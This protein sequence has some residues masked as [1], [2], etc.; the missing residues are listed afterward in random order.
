MAHRCGMQKENCPELFNDFCFI[1]FSCKD[2]RI[3]TC[4][5][6]IEWIR[7]NRTCTSLHGLWLPKKLR[8]RSDCSKFGRHAAAARG[9]QGSAVSLTRS[10]TSG[11]KPC[12]SHLPLTQTDRREEPTGGQTAALLPIRM[13]GHLHHP[14]EAQRTDSAGGGSSPLSPLLPMLSSA[15]PPPPPVL[16]SPSGKQRFPLILV[17]DLCRVFIFACAKMYGYH[18]FSLLCILEFVFKNGLHFAVSCLTG[19]L[20]CIT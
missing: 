3:R 19:V 18:T 17:L 20:H 5:D 9:P 13:G 14:R 10:L 4:S 7:A 1:S 15:P 8:K 12:M 2:I 11:P 16:P 6:N